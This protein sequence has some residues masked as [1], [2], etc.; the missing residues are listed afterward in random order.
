M[1]FYITAEKRAR[2]EKMANRSEVTLSEVVRRLI[3][4]GL[5]SYENTNQL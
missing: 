3:D 1:M 5:E 4:K 2:I